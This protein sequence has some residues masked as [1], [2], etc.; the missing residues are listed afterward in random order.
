[1]SHKKDDW[2]EKRACVTRLKKILVDNSKDES[3]SKHEQI[4]INIRY[5]FTDLSI[6]FVDK[7][8]AD[9]IF[10]LLLTDLLIANFGVFSHKSFKKILFSSK[11]S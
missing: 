1:M 4:T 10:W 7:Y 11:L 5:I 3:S 8:C 9:N 6:I 2:K